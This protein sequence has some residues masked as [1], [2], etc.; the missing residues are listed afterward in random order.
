MVWRCGSGGGATVVRLSL[1][2]SPTKKKRERER[3]KKLISGFFFGIMHSKI[4]L[5]ISFQSLPVNYL[6]PP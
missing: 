1:S 3:E 2:P 5:F 4:N 6:V